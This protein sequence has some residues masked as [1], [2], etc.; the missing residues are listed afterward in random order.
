MLPKAI[1]SL[2]GTLD[3]VYKDRI[4]GYRATLDFEQ[5]QIVITKRHPTGEINSLMHE[6]V[7]L[8]F[9]LAWGCVGHEIDEREE[10]AC[11]YLG[12]F[13]PKVLKDN[14]MMLQK[15]LPEINVLCEIWSVVECEYPDDNDDDIAFKADVRKQ[16]YRIGKNTSNDNK[17]LRI[18]TLTCESIL[19]ACRVRD[20]EDDYYLAMY[21]MLFAILKANPEVVK[22]CGDN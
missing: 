14:P 13:L 1:N 10:P 20:V 7:H 17:I 16:Q 11:S 4:P 5:G 15:P 3:V 6:L 21:S 9:L 19:E 22:M 8:A 2:V 12:R 18:F